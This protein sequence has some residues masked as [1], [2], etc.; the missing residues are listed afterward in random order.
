MAPRINLLLNRWILFTFSDASHVDKILSGIWTFKQGSLYIK[1]WHLISDP[2]HEYQPI[3]HLWMT[4]PGLPIVLWTEDILMG[5]ANAVGRF[6]RLDKQNLHGIDRRYAKVMVELDTRGGLPG[7]IEIAWGQKVWKQTLDYFK[8]PFRCY[9]CKQLGHVRATCPSSYKHRISPPLENSSPRVCDRL[10]SMDH[11]GKLYSNN[12]L[13][14]PELT[15]DDLVFIES[16]EK[17]LDSRIS[18]GEIQM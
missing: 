14:Y 1:R 4:I 8:I 10:P 15:P 2:L 3:R 16:S 9:S 11:S 17:I 13:N 18:K 12:P 5:I 6:V 7:E